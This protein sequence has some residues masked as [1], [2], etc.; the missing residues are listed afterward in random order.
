[1]FGATHTHTASADS[2]TIADADAE[3]EKKP[4][5]VEL[6]LSGLASTSF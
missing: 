6:A 4:T 2:V 3:C 5:G 1:M